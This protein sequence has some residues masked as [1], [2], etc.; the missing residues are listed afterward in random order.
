MKSTTT[1][2]IFTLVLIGVISC[3]PSG[4]SEKSRKVD[5]VLAAIGDEEKAT[6]VFTCGTP[7]KNV[8]N[9]QK[10]NAVGQ[11]WNK[12]VITWRY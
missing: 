5:N 2:G 8:S 3:F 7:D 12:Q 6:K 4:E 10:R 1:L 11:K 9:K